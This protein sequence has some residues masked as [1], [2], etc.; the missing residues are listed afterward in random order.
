[1]FLRIQFL[2]LLTLSIG[3]ITIQELKEGLANALEASINEEQG[4]DVWLLW[5]AI[6]TIVV[7]ISSHHKPHLTQ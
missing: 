4:L 3:V 6:K 2:C 7:K 1:M 5:N